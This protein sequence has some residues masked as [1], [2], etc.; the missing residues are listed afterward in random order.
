MKEEREVQP[1]ETFIDGEVKRKK[2]N[3]RKKNRKKKC[4]C[5]CHTV[6]T[7]TE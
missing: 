5:N 3:R 2:K 6:N 1:I 7:T 4:I